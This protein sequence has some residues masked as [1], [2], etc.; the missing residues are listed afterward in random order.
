[1]RYRIFFF[2]LLTLLSCYQLKGNGFIALNHEQRTP[3]NPVD[4]THYDYDRAGNLL[5]QASFL[6]VGLATMSYQYDAQGN[7]IS[8]TDPNGNR[9]I[10]SYNRQGEMLLRQYSDGSEERFSYETGGKI[11]THQAILGGHE[12]YTYTSTGLL[13]SVFHADGS[14]VEYH[15][16]LSGRMVEE[17]FSNGLYCQISYQG[18]IITQTF[19]DSGKN[20]GSI[21]ETYDGR[22]NLLQKIDL[23][24]SVWSYCY[25]GLNRLTLEQGPSTSSGTAAQSIKHIYHLGVESA[26]NALGERTNQIFDVLGRPTWKQVFNRDGTMAQQICHQYSSDHQSVT[27]TVGTG[28]NALIMSMYTDE[29]GRPTMLKHADGSFQKWDYDL[30]GNLIA[31]TDEIGNVTNYTYDKLNHLAS[32]QRP[33]GSVINYSYNAAGE[34]LARFMPQGLIEKNKYNDVGQKISSLLIGADGATTRNISYQYDQGLLTSVIDPRGEKISIDYDGWMHPVR[35]IASGASIPEQ[36]QT[37]TYCYN[38]Q[39][40]LT[41]VGQSYSDLSRGPST[42]VSKTYDAYGQL[43]LEK[44]SLDGRI[45]SAWKQAWDGAGRRKALS[46]DLGT[47]GGSAQYTFDYNALGLMTRSQNSS[48][49]VLCD[50]GDHGLLLSET[51]LAGQ[52]ILQRDHQGRLIH[53]ALSGKL[54]ETLSWKSNGKISSYSIVGNANETRNYDYDA[55]GRLIQ[56]PYML[57]ESADANTLSVGTHTATYAFDQLDIRM[58]QEVTPVIKNSIAKKNSFS[59]VTADDLSNGVN[60]MNP[61]KSSYDAAGA[62][63]AR[64]MEGAF[65]QELTWDSMG[66]LVCVSQ[67][68][69]NNQGYNWK[70]TYDGLGRRIQTSYC[71]ATGNQ[72]TSQPLAITY[73]NDPEVEFLELGR[74]YFGRTWNLYGPDRSGSYGGAQG[75]GGLAATSTEG[76][77]ETHGVV[78]DFFGN[79]IGITTDG[80]FQPWGNVLGG[81]G[82]M[83]GS[84]VN[85]DLVPQWRGRYLDWTGLYYM[86]TRYYEP[87]SGRFLSPDPLGYAASL[88]LYD[89][90]NGDPVNGLDPDGGRVEKQQQSDIELTTTRS[91]KTIFTNGTLRTR[92]DIFTTLQWAQGELVTY[93]NGDRKNQ[94]FLKSCPQASQR[95]SNQD[96]IM[97]LNAILTGEFPVQASANRIAQCFQLPDEVSVLINHCGSGWKDIPRVLLVN[98]FGCSDSC[99]L[100][101]ADIVSHNNGGGA[102]ASYMALS[103]RTQFNDIGLNPQ[104]YIGKAKLGF[105]GVIHAPNLS[106]AVSLFSSSPSL[107]Y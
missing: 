101:L 42:L 22:G 19:H 66:R 105:Q 36:N 54:E 102:A 5:Q 18:N 57:A 78:N 33:D 106:S 15:Y 97:S 99:S 30:N 93:L 80:I 8:S 60:K 1:M 51:T 13:K 43:V 72:T 14:S 79:S 91:K 39:G 59:Q 6:K 55:L 76:H 92:P 45:I 21:A 104:R 7:C 107:K 98:Q 35:V 31:S 64:S 82:A 83:P 24:G 52:K 49:E 40:A 94:S 58:K 85:T 88:S 20:L 70:T 69:K 86:G 81:Y 4:Y 67:R 16:D 63:T 56:E 71:D 37:T 75:I 73:Y 12:F 96:Q 90:C 77:A 95:L 68:N 47:D 32:E 25:D 44:T 89:Y 65:D 10:M 103:A 29:A 87:K 38:Q 41:S 62:V 28:S 17:I 23:G 11:A 9:T 3:L 27:T 74:D 53:Q 2:L 46:W 100:C 26:I 84:S 50:Y 34:L 61:W 48:G